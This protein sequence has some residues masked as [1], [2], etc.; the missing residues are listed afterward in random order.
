MEERIDDVAEERDDD[1]EEDGKRFAWLSGNVP[2]GILQREEMQ[3]VKAIIERGTDS[4]YSVYMDTEGYDYL[5]TATGA[6]EEEAK[7]DF[8]QA[9]EE[10]RAHYERERLPFKPASF[11]FERCGLMQNKGK[12]QQTVAHRHRA[13]LLRSHFI[14]L[15]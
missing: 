6:T 1:L 5:V 11:I 3:Q 7:A 9:Y 8:L 13:T 14:Y 4:R 2:E 12:M 15:F 10:M